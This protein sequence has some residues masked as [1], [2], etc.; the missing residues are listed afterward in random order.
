M[1]K[2]LQFSLY[3]YTLNHP[4][5]CQA[6]LSF[7]H[8]HISRTKT[9]YTH[10][11]LLFTPFYWQSFYASF[12]VHL[13]TAT[14]L[15]LPHILDVSS[16]SSSQFIAWAKAFDCG[17]TTSCTRFVREIVTLGTDIE[18]LQNLFLIGCGG[19]L[20]DENTSALFEKH[21]LPLVV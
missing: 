10:P 6:Y 4:L 19:A 13:T 21:K 12:F 20:M 8:P 17:A 2:L 14:P 5:N 11:R 1:P 18:F 15:A 16:L 7:T 9:P 3:F